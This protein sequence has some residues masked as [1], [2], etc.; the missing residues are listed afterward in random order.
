MVHTELEQGW[1]SWG[2]ED[3]FT[4]DI[5]RSTGLELHKLERQVWRQEIHG[6]EQLGSYYMSQMAAWTVVCERRWK[7]TV[8]AEA[9]GPA[10]GLDELGQPG[11]KEES[12]VLWFEQLMPYTELLL[13]HLQYGVFLCCPVEGTASEDEQWFP[14]DHPQQPRFPSNAI[15]LA[16]QLSYADPSFLNF[17]QPVICALSFFPHM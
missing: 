16:I 11:G 10:S 4:P 17:S 14:G 7:H 15:S 3:Q 9:T 1:G 12:M 2:G 6:G 8:E 13:N 5:S